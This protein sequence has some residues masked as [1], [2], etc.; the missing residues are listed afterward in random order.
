MREPPTEDPQALGRVSDQEWHYVAVST[1]LERRE[2]HRQQTSVP[3][4]LSQ[5]QCPPRGAVVV[6]CCLKAKS[7]TF[8]HFLTANPGSEHPP[9]VGGGLRGEAQHGGRGRHNA[10]LQELPVQGRA[11]PGH[12]HPHAAQRDICSREGVKRQVG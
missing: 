11:R 6:Y 2:W 10:G 7:L 1:G 4:E 5:N 12:R 9:Y 3:R 8:P